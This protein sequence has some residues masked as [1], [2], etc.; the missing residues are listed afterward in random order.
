MYTKP[1]LMHAWLAHWAGRRPDRPE[2]AD[3]GD[4]LAAAVL[5]RFRAHGT[6]DEFNASTYDGVDLVAAALWCSHDGA[7]AAAT[8]QLAP[9]AVVTRGTFRVV[10]RRG[11]S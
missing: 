4:A 3:R 6:V 1:A 9:L 5:D 7:K 10:D 2:R 8:G 11:G